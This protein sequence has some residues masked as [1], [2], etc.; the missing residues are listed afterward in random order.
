MRLP[1]NPRDWEKFILLGVEIEL[2]KSKTYGPQGS[3]GEFTVKF[4]TPEGDFILTRIPTA[5][6]GPLSGLVGQSHLLRV[7]LPQ[8][9]LER[10]EPPRDSREGSLEPSWQS[11]DE[12]EGIE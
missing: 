4:K 12:G 10:L 1:S 7:E 9:P 2:T 6:L 11:P 3:R 8:N 5:L